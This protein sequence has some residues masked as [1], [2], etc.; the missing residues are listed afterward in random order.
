MTAPA[1]LNVEFTLGVVAPECA[2]KMPVGDHGPVGVDCETCLS[3]YNAGTALV[4]DYTNASVLILAEQVFCFNHWLD[5][6]RMVE[7]KN[8]V[9]S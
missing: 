4:G 8:G 2:Q 5:V 1:L 3:K 7:H 6:A 9:S